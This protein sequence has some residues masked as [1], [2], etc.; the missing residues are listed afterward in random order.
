MTTNQSQVP[1]RRVEMTLRMPPDMARAV[2]NSAKLLSMTKSDFLRKS[3]KR[4]LEYV[5]KNEL[6][7]IETNSRLKEALA[8]ELTE[9][10]R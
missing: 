4:N 7:L 10:A 8:V 1:V 2:T 3:V 5:L 9:G 6:P